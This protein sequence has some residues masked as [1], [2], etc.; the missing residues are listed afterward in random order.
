M[1][2]GIIIK[3]VAGQYTVDTPQGQYVCSARGLF[4]KQK[5]TPVVG[6]RVKINGSTLSEILPRR[7]ELQRPR[8]ANVDQVMVVLSI[9]QPAFDFTM[10]DR[11]LIHAEHEGIDAVI[12]IN[13][14]DLVDADI[15]ILKKVHDIYTQAG[16][17]VFTAS[18]NTYEGIETIKNI[19]YGKITVLAGPS[20]VGKSSI[21]NSLDL[22]AKVATGAVS[23]KIGRGKHTTRHAE[24]IPILPKP[25]FSEFEYLPGYVIDTPGFS[26]LDL[27]NVELTERAVL[28]REFHPMLGQCKFRDCLHRS[29]KD[30]AVKDQVGISINPQRYACYIDWIAN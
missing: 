21:I 9:V 18:A 11:Y 3:G 12:C 27:P 17:S 24:F 6:D 10:L 13:K 7:N 25:E 1:F 16:Y 19:L 14:M 28:F 15:D 26:S 2:E 22:E 29:E 30:C 23:E 4:R 20:G 5:I 8:I